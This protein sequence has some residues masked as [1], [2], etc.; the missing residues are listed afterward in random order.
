MCFRCVRWM[1]TDKDVLKCRASCHQGAV[2]VENMEA[3]LWGERCPEAVHLKAP[4]LG[5]WRKTV[6]GLTRAGW[7]GLYSQKTSTQ[8]IVSFVQ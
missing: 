4:L 8:Y 2:L 1:R 5:I 3:L 7:R 6:V